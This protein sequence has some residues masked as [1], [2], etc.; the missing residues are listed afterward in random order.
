MEEIKWEKEFETG[1]N[2]IDTQHKNFTQKLK[3]FNLAIKDNRPTLEVIRILEFLETYIRSHFNLEEKYMVEYNYPE[4][5]FHMKEHREFIKVFDVLKKD[6]TGNS[7]KTENVLALQYELWQ[8]FTNHI[9]IIDSELARFLK[10]K[11][12]K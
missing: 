1:V 6:L 3:K 12:A 11:G 9:S 5:K 7:K 10:S 2:W 4:K 8:Y